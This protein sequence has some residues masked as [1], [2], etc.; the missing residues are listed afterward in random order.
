MCLPATAQASTVE[1]AADG[2]VIVR[3]AAGETNNL[4]IKPEGTTGVRVRDFGAHAA[5]AA[6][7]P[8]CPSGPEIVCRSGVVDVDVAL[9]DGN[10][11]Y[12]GQHGF[13]D[14]RRR[15]APATTS[16]STTARPG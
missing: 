3:A 9:G 2:T 10:D 11:L 15:R 16:T 7:A 13:A 14:R 8:A 6:A 5:R 1:L 12:A 4:H